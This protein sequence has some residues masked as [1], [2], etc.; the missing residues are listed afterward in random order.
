MNLQNVTWSLLEM[1]TQILI[2]SQLNVPVPVSWDY[3]E[4]AGDLGGSLGVQNMRAFEGRNFILTSS[5]AIWDGV[6]GLAEASNLME[7]S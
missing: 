3:T 5:S 7:R 6:G 1:T 2:Y 4:E